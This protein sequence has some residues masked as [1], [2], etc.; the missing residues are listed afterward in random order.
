MRLVDHDEEVVWEVVDEAVRRLARL[1]L[2]DVP[3]VVLDAAAEPDLL[4]HLEV[5]GGAHPQALG[6]EQLSLARSSWARRS[7]SSTLMVL[8]GTRA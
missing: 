2:V 1:A 4:H 5:E 3:R 7:A 6:L 8:D